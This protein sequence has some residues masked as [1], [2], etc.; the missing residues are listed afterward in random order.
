MSTNK[1]PKTGATVA[2][3]IFGLLFLIMLAMALWSYK[4]LIRE[5]PDVL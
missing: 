4:K 1:K 3:G 5:I 2:K